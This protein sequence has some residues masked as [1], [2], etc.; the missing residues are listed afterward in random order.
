MSNTQ[1]G[2]LHAGRV[3]VVVGVG[4]VDG[5]PVDELKYSWLQ[6]KH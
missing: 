3:F 5:L 2:L 1:F 4:G 6:K